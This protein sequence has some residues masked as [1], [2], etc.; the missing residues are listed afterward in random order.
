MRR[1]DAGRS[2]LVVRYAGQGPIPGKLRPWVDVFVHWR[3]ML[4]AYS[5]AAG[6]QGW[7]WNERPQVG[8]LAAAVWRAGGVALT[9]YGVTK[10]AL[11]DRRRRCSGRGDLW[12]QVGGASHLIEAKHKKL[13]ID[14]PRTRETLSNLL[15]NAGWDAVRNLDEVDYRTAVCFVPLLSARTVDDDAW[16]RFLNDAKTQDL[17]K[18]VFDRG[19]RI[20]LRSGWNHDPEDE[21]TASYVGITLLVGIDDG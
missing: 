4:E 14:T 7:T 21:G 1:L 3:D 12:A 15:D 19:F 10:Q 17:I 6:D 5:H 8:F 11:A 18:G 16:A 13:R 2:D 20:D 9:E